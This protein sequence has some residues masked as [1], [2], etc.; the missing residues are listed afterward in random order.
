MQIIP[1]SKENIFQGNLLLVN[2]LHPLVPKYHPENIVSIAN[3]A[4]LLEK[5]VYTIIQALLEDIEAFNSIVFVSGYRS[6]QEQ[7][8]IW[9]TSIKENGEVFTRQYVALPQ[10]SEHQSGLAI[11]VGLQQD[12]IDFIRPYFP[13]DGIA[14]KFREKANQYGFI[15][16]YQE[17]KETITGISYEPWHFRYVG[18]P[19]ACIM[20]ELHLCLEEY[21]EYIK[22]FSQEQPLVYTDTTTME[23]FYVSSNDTKLLLP[24]HQVYQISGNNIDG[25][26]VTL[27]RNMHG[28]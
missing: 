15:E 23:V 25:F 5:K 20:H 17:D 7:K 22:Q 14:Q 28:K 11:D 26:I 18:H 2:A 27:W 6:Y 19:H 3:T 16:R 12:T 13:S 8:D 4:I 9:D 24:E 1:L 10:A 21:M